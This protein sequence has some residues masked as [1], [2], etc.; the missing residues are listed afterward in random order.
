M[1]EPGISR[2]A[3]WVTARSARPAP[4]RASRTA[5]PRPPSGWWSSAMTSRPPV[6]AAAAARVAVSAG[7][8]EYRSMTRALMPSRGQ[9]AGRGQALV[10][11]D[12]GAD[13]GHLVIAALAQHLGPADREGLPRVVQH[14][15]GAPGGPQVGDARP[16]GHG[17]HQGGGAGRVARVQHG[18]AV[19]G[20][21][22][23][24]VLQRHLGRAVGADLDPGV[25]PGQADAGPGDGR[26]PDEIIGPGEE[27]GEGR[28]ERPVAAHG[29][30]H[31]GGDQ[32][33]LGDEHLEVP[34]GVGLGELIGERRVAHLAVHGHHV[35][36]DARAR[37]ARPRRPC[38]WR[39]SGPGRRP[40]A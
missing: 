13:Q 9:L 37:P 23:G 38:G 32:L 27:R 11:G 30:A 12:P 40:A 24:Q 10:Q 39:P 29:D 14:R 20:A 19:H 1:P 36:A 35:G 18:G 22:H 31:R 16:V 21:E 3:R 8:T 15:V 26:H 17:Q 5:D 7:L 34:L 2:T 28:R 25:R 4:V 33:L 6:A